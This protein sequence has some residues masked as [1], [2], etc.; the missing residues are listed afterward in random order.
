[1]SDNKIVFS[2]I[3]A[4]RDGVKEQ[5]PKDENG[6]Y[7]ITLGALNIYNS[8][9]AFYT[10]NGAKQ[11]FEASSRLMRRINNGAL[12]AE[13]GHP[14]KLPGMSMNDYMNRIIQIDIDNV[15]AHIKSVELVET[16]VCDK[17]STAKMILIKG[18]V[19]PH[20]PKAQYLID[21]L[22]DPDANVCFSIRSLTNDVISNGVL[23]KTLKEII[24]WDIVI[25]PGLHVATKWKSLGIE[26]L[27]LI[28][29]D[30]NDST[31]INSLKE[32]LKEMSN[33][34]TEDSR[35]IS[36]VILKEFD[37]KKNGSC[38]LHKW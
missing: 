28:S 31:T 5:L 10:A 30:L 23:I 11:L 12:K 3:K 34:G 32:S 29:V 1:M 16:D 38:I 2:S 22:E 21:L 9:G 26:S 35:E 27:D 25:E 14:K 4:K 6:Y 19:K 17:N 20:G 24:T 13:L 8:A 33:I 18:W 37:C 7:Y 15:G 36:N